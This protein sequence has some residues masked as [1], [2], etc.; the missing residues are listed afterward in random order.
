MF[1]TMSGTLFKVLPDGSEAWRFEADGTIFGSP[2][3]DPF[4]NIRF[5]TMRS[6]FYLIRSS[7]ELVGTYEDTSE[8]P[9]YYS[10][11]PLVDVAGR[12]YLGTID[13][14]L[15]C[16]RD[17]V[18]RLQWKADLEGG[19]GKL[20]PERGSGAYGSVLLDADGQLYVPC[21]NGYL[22]CL[23]RPSRAVSF[24][25]QRAENQIVGDMA[26][27]ECPDD[28]ASLHRS[29]LPRSLGCS[30][31]NRDPLA[32]T[33][34][35]DEAL[36]LAGHSYESLPIVT[37]PVYRDVYRLNLVEYVLEQAPDQ[38]PA[39]LRELA[40][41][42]EFEAVSLTDKIIEAGAMADIV[43]E[44]PS[45]SHIFG[46]APLAEA[47]RAVYKRHGAFLTATQEEYLNTVGSSIDSSIQQALGLLI[48]AMDEA[49]R[50]RDEALDDLEDIEREK[51]FRDIMNPNFI[52]N[53]SPLFSNFEIYQRIDKGKILH[54]G[55]VIASVIDSLL[56][57]SSSALAKC[58]EKASKS[59][60][61]SALADDVLFTFETPIGSIIL[62]GAG[63][64]TYRIMPDVSKETWPALLVDLGGNDTYKHYLPH[65]MRDD[66][67]ASVVIDV[68]G[69]DLYDSDG[70]NA[71]GAGCLGAGF[72]ID[73]GGDD[74]YVA[75][76]FSQGAGWGGVG[77]LYDSFGADQYY[78]D[79][80]CQGA[81]FM[82]V[83][84]LID[85]NGDDVYSVDEHGQAFGYIRGAGV[86][87]DTR[88]DD[89]YFAGGEYE[90]MYEPPRTTS[91]SQGYGFG[92][93]LSQIGDPHASG[94]VG[95]L[96]D[97]AGDD[98]FVS[99]FFGT[100]GAY[101][102]GLGM[103]M[104]RSGNDTYMARQYSI[105]S[106]IHLA[107]GLLV[108]DDGD[109]TYLCRSL[110]QGCAHDNSVGILVDNAGDD[111]Y[112]A[113]DFSQ[114]ATSPRSFSAL[115]DNGG[116][117]MYWAMA[118]HLNQ[119][120]SRYQSEGGRKSSLSILLDAGG[121]DWYQIK[122]EDNMRWT[123]LYYGVCIDSP[124]GNSGLH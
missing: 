67:A 107:V 7:G 117:D 88:G 17:S 59:G 39:V 25:S 114:S 104:N 61:H 9:C 123:Q 82:G 72:C 53:L 100:A 64:N 119:G 97:S 1:G 19:T 41:A 111:I 86:L 4:G 48:L 47:I 91:M 15:L 110:S 31:L 115:V 16:I 57:F 124:F 23:G 116:N 55:A 14:S 71:Q 101:W 34:M 63:D 30:A 112:L 32:P 106:G 102:L 8:Y 62:G 69:D 28:V 118:G 22:Y 46:E 76:H 52:S 80:C 18:T 122:G 26:L 42:I 10:A 81:G 92:V 56:G 54:G 43:V 60:G 108:D 89:L 90:H 38:G 105:A 78:G 6:S 33:T 11:S 35:L 121:N 20:L 5:G 45:F 65:D 21:M 51:V 74:V 120:E 66:I 109:D 37:W 85:E 3:I 79:T 70:D 58:A 113:Q 68:A 13:R 93:R 40:D 84:L 98:T 83:G 29:L 36:K 2:S 73:M 99:D 94:G 24:D 50:L 49:T 27:A 87:L 95:L 12:S 77:I 44:S 103:L 75:G 96:I